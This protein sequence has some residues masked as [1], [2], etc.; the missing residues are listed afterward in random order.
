MEDENPIY[1][2]NMA[3]SFVIH[4]IA[5]PHLP[6][7]FIRLISPNEFSSY[8]ILSLMHGSYLA[9]RIGFEWGFLTKW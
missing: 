9:H 3:D 8:G 1:A 7:R 2:R 5:L 4:E 6:H